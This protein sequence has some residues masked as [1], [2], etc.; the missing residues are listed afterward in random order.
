M[1]EGKGIAP[2]LPDRTGAERDCMLPRQATGES[3]P[4]LEPLAHLAHPLEAGIRAK[5]RF[6]FVLIFHNL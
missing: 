4:H 2:G 3:S 6:L 1:P 5:Y